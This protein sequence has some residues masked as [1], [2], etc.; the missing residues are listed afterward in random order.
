MAEIDAEIDGDDST[1][2]QEVGRRMADSSDA[3]GHIAVSQGLHI[4]R[5]EQFLHTYVWTESRDDVRVG[6]YVQVPVGGEGEDA[7]LFAV[8]NAMNYVTEQITINDLDDLALSGG[9]EV[10]MDRYP[11]VAVLDPIT[12]LRPDE[13]AKEGLARRAVDTLPRPFSQV[14]PVTDSR[15]IYRGLNLPP[16]GIAVGRVSVGGQQVTD[17]GGQNIVY[18]LLDPEPESPRNPS[19]F[20]HMLVAGATGKGKTQM[21]K[22]VIRQF[23]GGTGAPQ[24]QIEDEN[25]NTPTKEPCTVIIDPENEY[26]QLAKDN[27]ELTKEQESELAEYESEGFRVGGVD[28]CVAFIP[29]VSGSDE[30][31]TDADSNFYFSVPFDIVQGRPQLLMPFRAGEPTKNAIRTLVNDYF[32][33]QQST[34]YSDFINWVETSKPQYVE[35]GSMHESSWDAMKNRIEMQ[36]YYNV[37]D[38]DATPLTE[39]EDEI[40]TS[41]RVS[42]IP[43]DHIRGSQERVVVMSLL[44]YIVENKLKTFNVSEP[45]KYT[46]ILLCVDEAHNYL[47]SRENA[48]EA[49]II[50]KFVNAA[51]QG[52]KERLGLY[53]V[54]Q[55]PVD[56]DEE[57]R[58]Q[59]NTKMYLGL[60]AAT[61]RKVEVPPDY[62]D[63]IPVFGQGQAVIKAPDVEAVEIQ[64][65]PI[66]LTKHT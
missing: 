29:K 48:Q 43:T 32:N 54:T 57:I 15:Y 21:S 59:T 66:C 10:D 12:I 9:Q 34:S 63:R 13:D 5:D 25:S 50:S 36:F 19:I 55:N 62:V 65:L 52:R 31:Q 6:D 47:S 61:V 22:N 41:G 45:V 16:T 40:F 3:Y 60:E 46:P 58:H 44:A 7:Y 23:A 8:V 11:L 17:S 39:I 27:P 14:N 35:G 26:S 1:V 37:F 49:Y 56:I 28:D 18:N 4:G 51:K 20:R 33:S 53:M 2:D 64:G 38:Q 42:V 30:V 24:Y